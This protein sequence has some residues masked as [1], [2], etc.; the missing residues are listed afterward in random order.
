[1]TAALE[2]PTAKPL[3][4]NANLRAHG[5]HWCIAHPEHYD[6]PRYTNAGGE[7]STHTI[8]S[9]YLDTHFAEDDCCTPNT[10]CHRAA[11][12]LLATGRIAG[13]R[14][15]IPA[16]NG[17]PTTR[18]A[19]PATGNGEPLTAHGAPAPRPAEP[20]QTK[21]GDGASSTRRGRKASGP[22]PITEKQIALVMRLAA[23]L[24]ELSDTPNPAPLQLE[25]V[26]QLSAKEA[27]GL[28]DVFMKA[29]KQKRAERRTEER[30]KVEEALEEDRYYR[31][32][33]GEVYQVRRSQSSGRL[34]A[35]QL[36]ETE[37]DANMEFA[38]GALRKLAPAMEMTSEETLELLERLGRKTG[39][40]MVCSRTLTN[41]E[42][43]KQGI[44]PVCRTRV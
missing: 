41:P 3:V 2:P 29:A 13:A 33:D 9:N 7:T 44:G 18:V 12:Y 42:S 8:A 15:Y 16:R 27:S 25:A 20:E 11:V 28:I 1:M 34:Y 6:G 30:A 14:G 36:A 23:E 26:E 5:P 35:L 40:C 4:P 43:K 39:V 19:P 21:G 10:P 24:D 37:E 22:K 38:P 31:T 17:G 32:D